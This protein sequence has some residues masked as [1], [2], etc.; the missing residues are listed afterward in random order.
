MSRLQLTPHSTTWD[1]SGLATRTRRTLR[2]SLDAVEALDDATIAEFSSI[3]ISQMTRDEILRVIRAARLP[4]LKSG[5]D[6][7]LE[8]Y[9]RRTLERLVYLSRHCCRNRRMAMPS[10][11]SV[12]P[13]G[14]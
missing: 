3:K 9:D 2:Q 10:R 7:Q 14:G 5:I 12:F 4:L 1:R 13:G 8:F 6:E 11:P